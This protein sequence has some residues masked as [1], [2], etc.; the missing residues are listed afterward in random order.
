MLVTSH[1]KLNWSLI[2]TSNVNVTLIMLVL[3][4]MCNICCLRPDDPQSSGTQ[5]TPL[6]RGKLRY[7]GFASPQVLLFEP[8]SRI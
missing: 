5:I 4:K 6:A 3:V 7:R 1:K 2:V 8:K